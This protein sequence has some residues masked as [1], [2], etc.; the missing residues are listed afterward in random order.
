MTEVSLDVVGQITCDPGLNGKCIGSLICEIEAI[1]GKLVIR[2]GKI[3]G[4]HFYDTGHD[5][6]PGT[7]MISFQTVEPNDAP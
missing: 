1:D 6:P 2:V 5:H 3:I 7:R 4:F